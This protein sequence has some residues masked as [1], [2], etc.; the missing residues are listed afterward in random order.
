MSLVRVATKFFNFT[1][2]LKF[3]VLRQQNLIAPNIENNLNLE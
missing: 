3:S 2:F 1:K